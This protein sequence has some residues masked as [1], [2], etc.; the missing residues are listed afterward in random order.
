[1]LTR[2]NPTIKLPNSSINPESFTWHSLRRKDSI[3][4]FQIIL[5]IFISTSR[6]RCAAYER[7]AFAYYALRMS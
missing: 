3:S 6:L 5:E 1:M 2:V 4:K 7:Y